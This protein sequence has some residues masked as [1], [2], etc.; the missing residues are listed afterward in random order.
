MGDPESFYICPYCF[1][2]C[3]KDIHCHDHPMVHCIPGRWGVPARKPVSDPCGNLR[4]S[5][6]RWYLEAVGWIQA[7]GR[8]TP[9]HPS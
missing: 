5:A 9:L 6:P 7:G 4:S 2:I 1:S 8:S 3:D